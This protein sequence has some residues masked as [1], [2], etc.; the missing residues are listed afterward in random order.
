MIDETNWLDI[1]GILR[2]EIFGSTLLFVIVCGIAIL[3]FCTYKR[4]PWQLHI[5]FLLL[6]GFLVFALYALTW[7]LVATLF[8]IGMVIYSMK[9]M[10]I[11]Q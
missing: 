5:S 1:T 8:M 4:M 11:T 2:N 7:A 9:K 10:V 6:F 3:Y